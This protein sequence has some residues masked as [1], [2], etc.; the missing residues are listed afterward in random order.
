MGVTGGN[1]L[2]LYGM[3]TTLQSPNL[4]R[5]YLVYVGVPIIKSFLFCWKVDRF[6]PDKFVIIE[7]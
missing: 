5:D 4:G 7:V 3:V 2:F 1:L 6:V